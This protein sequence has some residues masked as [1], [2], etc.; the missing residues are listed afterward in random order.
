MS[1]LNLFVKG[2]EAHIV[3]DTAISTVGVLMLFSNKTFILPDLGIAVG[4]RGRFGL[5]NRIRYEFGLHGDPI[6]ALDSLPRQLRQNF[7][8]LAKLFPK[9]YGF[10][11]GIA[12]HADGR[13][14]ARLLSSI[15]RPA[16]PAFRW[17]DIGGLWASPPIEHS[18]LREIGYSLMVDQDA[19]AVTL[20]DA[21]RKGRAVSIGGS[22]Q[23]TTVSPNLISTRMLKRYPDTR[24]R[25]IDTDSEPQ[26]KGLT[27]DTDWR[28]AS[29]R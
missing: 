23:I 21:Q 9:F 20:V 11:I 28:T 25:K 15:E 1:A 24:G 27:P 16:Q 18:A 17:T 10:D 3:T 4:F 2:D 7:G 14:F 6:E 8:L 22:V 5:S 26:A 19:A 13:P 12:G 29:C